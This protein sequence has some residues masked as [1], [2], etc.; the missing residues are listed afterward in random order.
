MTATADAPHVGLVVE[1]RGD[2]F[3]VPAM[4]RKYLTERGEYR[5][6]L[7]KPVPCHGRDKAVAPGGIE[8]YVATAA[9]RPGCRGVLAI[10]D[11]EGDGVCELGPLLRER[12]QT[13]TGKPV[14]VCLAEPK[15]EAWLVASAESMEL[16][17]LTYAPDRD[18]IALI[19]G[20]MNVKYAKP[21]WQPRLASR[22]DFAVARPRSR[23]LDRL[24]S[25]LDDLAAA[26]A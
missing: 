10:L 19:K 4:L 24:L 15:F 5:D 3:A 25:K 2:Q 12:A 21:T 13:T 17:G 22:L 16:E 1:G 6:I 7:G 14:F 20:A 8:G 11:G 9:T 23:S 18:S 26:L